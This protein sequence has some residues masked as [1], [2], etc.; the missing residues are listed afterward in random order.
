MLLELI[1]V[2][3]MTEKQYFQFTKPSSFGAN[4]IFEKNGDIFSPVV[5]NWTEDDFKKLSGG[6]GFKDVIKLDSS[7]D[8]VLTA[9][10][11][12]KQDGVVLPKGQNYEIHGR[13]KAEYYDTIADVFS[14]KI[15]PKKKIKFVFKNDF[16][17]GLAGN[18]LSLNSDTDPAYKKW[19]EQEKASMAGAHTNYQDHD[20]IIINPDSPAALVKYSLAHELGHAIFRDKK[21]PDNLFNENKTSMSGGGLFRKERLIDKQETIADHFSDFI[22]LPEV[23]KNNYPNEYAYFNNLL[24]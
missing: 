20:E 18:K 10:P 16:T 2:T 11:I 21:I 4:A 3:I 6:K 23:Y 17:T 24:K 12:Y 9:N 8:E 1:I 13:T 5:G 7:L 19:S 22:N 14:K 15:K